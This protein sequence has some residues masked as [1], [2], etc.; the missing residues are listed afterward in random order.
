MKSLI[1][2]ILLA[3]LT[4]HELICQVAI[5]TDGEEADPTSILDLKSDS[6]GILIP[7]MTMAQLEAILDPA[8]GLLVF[9]TTDNN[10]FVN[11]GSPGAPDWNVVSSRWSANGNHIYYTS[12]NIGIG[13]NAPIVK[14]D[15]RGIN[16]DEAATLMLSNA[17]IS[18]KLLFFS[19]Q[20][21]DPNPIIQWKQGD[22]LRF[23]TDEGGGTE[24]IRINSNGQ[25]GIG[26]ATPCSSA[27]V[28]LNSANQGFLPPRMTVSQRMG[29]ASPVAGLLVYQ[30][31]PP[32]GYY[33][34]NG[35]N[36]EYLVNSGIISGCIDYDGHGYPTIWIGGKEWMAENLHVAH[37]RNGDAIPFVTDETDWVNLTTG[38]CCWYSNDSLSY[39][40]YGLYYNWY[41]V[42][43]GRALCPA[44]WHVASEQEYT[45]LTNYLGGFRIAGGKVKCV[46]ELWDYSNTD[47]TNI[48]GFSGLPGGYR[49]TLGGFLNEGASCALW[50][51]T[52]WDVDHGN[53]QDVYYNT[54]FLWGGYERKEQGRSV[55]C[56]RD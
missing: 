3:L 6:K 15:I 22:A 25:V 19:G 13:W 7:R 18:H 24:R 47:A 11:R 40:K 51:A 38:A 41:A 14:L 49:N 35:L 39:K 33:Y 34:Y 23:G 16:L 55:R 36:W 20:Q 53:T 48:S 46:T 17:D 37:Y 45:D 9:S 27:L 43:D 56:V 31:D 54:G 12:G 2:I 32:A 21:N 10:F 42:N 4:K 50:T 1:L 29:I 26:T 52:E 30:T 8:N 28:E 44:G 5:N